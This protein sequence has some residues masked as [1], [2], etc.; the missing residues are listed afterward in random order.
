VNWSTANGAHRRRPVPTPHPTRRPEPAQ[1]AT[2]DRQLSVRSGHL[3]C[4]VRCGHQIKVD[5]P[6][7]K[8]TEVR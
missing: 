1:A 7:V 3:A 4:F 6:Q 5:G 8:P 2:V